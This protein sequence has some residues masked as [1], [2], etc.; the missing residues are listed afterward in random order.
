MHR[1]TLIA[2]LF[3]GELDQ[4]LCFHFPP[5][6]CFSLLS[7]SLFFLENSQ[8][9]QSVVNKHFQNPHLLNINKKIKKKVVATL[10]LPPESKK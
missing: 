1:F 7:T 9:K 5:L 10:S 8:Q 3:T 4:P 6:A 2:L